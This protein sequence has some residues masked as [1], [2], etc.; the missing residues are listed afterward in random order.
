MVGGGVVAG[1]EGVEAQER[2]FGAREQLG[3]LGEGGGFDGV[4]LLD[5]LF[6]VFVGHGCG[7]GGVGGVVDEW[8]VEFWRSFSPVCGKW[9][10]G[11]FL[12]VRDG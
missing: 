3:C 11:C 12:L 10:S 8:L 2:E 6:E 5:D 9:F 1:D 4:E 7:C